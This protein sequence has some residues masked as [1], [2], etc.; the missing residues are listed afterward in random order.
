MLRLLAPRL[1]GGHLLALVLVAVACGLG[2]WQISAWQA[3]REAETA[4]LSTGPALSLTEVMGPDDPYP[5]D[6]VGQP[7]DVRGTW[8]PDGTVLVEGRER[9]G[10]TG[11][12]AATPVEVDGG[13]GSGLYVVRGWAATREEVPPAP[14]GR[15]TLTAW[16]QPTEGTNQVDAD[17]TDDVLPQL[18]TADL[19]QHVDQDLYGAFAVA[20]E[21]V[22]AMAPAELTQLPEASASTGLKNLLYGIEWFVFGGFAGFIWWRWS[23]DELERGR[24]AQEP[25]E[26]RVASPT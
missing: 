1:W 25:A 3:H 18:R 22:G 12:W 24:R 14:T 9:D 6:R 5:A 20:R 2:V 19:V 23:R 7:V 10:E 13:G 8:V 15:A 16:L 26:E 17:R 21:P 11:Y 4:D